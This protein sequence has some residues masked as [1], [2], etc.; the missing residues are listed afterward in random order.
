LTTPE[1]QGP[2]AAI[3][4]IAK[5]VQA[6]NK[7]QGLND[8]AAGL[9]FWAILSVF[10]AVLAFTS[11]LGSMELLVGKSAADEL[12]QD[13]VD[14]LHRTLPPDSEI[15]TTITNIIQQSRAGLAI[16]G[17]LTAGWGM[18]KGFA[19]LCRG[20]ALVDGHPGARYGIKGRLIGLALGL[21][22]LT[23]MTVVLLQIIVGPLLGF[24]KLLPGTSTLLSVWEVVRWPVLAV[25]V[26]VW[27]TT[28][29]HIGPGPNPDVRW[30]DRLPGAVFTAAAWVAVTFGFKLYVTIVGG[31]N[32]VLGVLGAAIV[33]LTWLYLLAV[34]TL[35]GAELNAVLADRRAAAARAPAPMP[36]P[37]HPAPVPGAVGAGVVAAAFVFGRRAGSRGPR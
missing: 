25:L 24:E 4:A 36:A 28:L 7:A 21:A 20:L 1:R 5:E 2:G 3:L 35:V 9:S 26:V 17:L 6:R 8:V 27:L 32:P 10:P 37:A 33:S 22:T 15:T 19:G 14:F 30:R 34:T 12:R 13:I 18:S 23:L 16:V 29:L 11:L 31:A